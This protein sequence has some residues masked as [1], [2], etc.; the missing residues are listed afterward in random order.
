MS[1]LAALLPGD[2]N[3]G[4]EQSR[5]R[6][7]RQLAARLAGRV[8]F[9]APRL[10]DGQDVM[11]KVDPLGRADRRREQQEERQQRKTYLSLHG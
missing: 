3:V 5:P 9:R 11:S 4:A 1:G 10:E 2:D 7:H 8:A 6:I